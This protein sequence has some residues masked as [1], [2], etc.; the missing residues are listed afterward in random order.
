MPT[1]LR[2]KGYRFFFYS[3]DGWEPAHV[4]V[5]KDAK[6]AKI[7]LENVSVAVNMGFTAQDLNE[8]VKKTREERGSFL[9]SWNDYFAN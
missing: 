3:A 6:E 8:I 9:R 7:W 4:H 2:W 5:T 1:V